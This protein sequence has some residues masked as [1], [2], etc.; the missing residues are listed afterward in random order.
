MNNRMMIS[1]I[2]SSSL[3]FVI[4]IVVVVVLYV[5][6][7][8]SGNEISNVSAPSAFESLVLQIE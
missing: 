3:S 4:V 6:S 1:F 8:E 2:I 7:K 5:T